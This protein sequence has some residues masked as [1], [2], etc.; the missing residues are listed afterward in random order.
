[1]VEVD[2]TSGCITWANESAV[3]A[4][5]RH[6][7]ELVGMSLHGLIAESHRE[8][9]LEVMSEATSGNVYQKTLWP[10]SG[11][12][13][14]YWWS[15]ELLEAPEP[16]EDL[17]WFYCRTASVTDPSGGSY[18]V[19]SISSEGMLSAAAALGHA[20][21][22]SLSLTKHMK[23]VK[24]E[25]SS[26]RDEDEKTRENIKAAIR[27]AGAAAD[28]AMANKAATDALI[29][30]VSEQFDMHT[31]E[32]LRLISSDAAN[33]ARMKV[34]EDQVKKTTALAIRSVVSTADKA[35]RGLSKRVTIP[36]GVIAAVLTFIQWLITN[37]PRK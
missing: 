21:A 7:G 27:A 36:V 34:F 16:G 31:V 14:V 30:R 29:S 6:G 4:C 26:L 25:V 24:D 22:S 1:M 15:A 10:V 3:T 28:A 5:P 32:I 37:W 2:L 23:A 17:A 18:D 33:D 9:L 13:K 35:G 19:A 8:K 20:R 11:G 12:T